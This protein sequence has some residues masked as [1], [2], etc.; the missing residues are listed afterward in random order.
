MKSISRMYT[1][2][3]LS[4]YTWLIDTSYAGFVYVKYTSRHRTWQSDLSTIGGTTRLASR[5]PIPTLL[6]SFR[7]SIG[8]HGANQSIYDVARV[9]THVR[10]SPIYL[11]HPSSRIVHHSADL[12]RSIRPVVRSMYPSFVRPVHP[13]SIVRI[14][15]SLC[16]VQYMG[17]FFRPLCARP[18]FCLSF[19]VLVTLLFCYSVTLLLCY[20][21]TMLLCYSVTLL[22]C[23]SVTLLPCYSVTLLLCYYVTLLLCYS[24]TLLL[25]YS[26][27]LLL[28]YS[29]TLL[30]CYS[31]TLLLCYSVHQSYKSVTQSIVYP[32]ITLLPCP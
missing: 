13:P 32:N 20:S 14:R 25:C 21:V 31:V 22:L 24:V 18:S 2:T 4:W 23:Y 26:V 3:C 7:K 10:Q 27:T 6:R 11:T 1:I 29:V 16:R 5:K 8:M 30:L 12:Q 15:S 19:D 17:H 28:C 9:I